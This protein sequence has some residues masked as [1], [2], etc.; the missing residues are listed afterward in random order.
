PTAGAA[1]ASTAPRRG[2]PA[3]GS[4]RLE[5][6]GC[7]DHVLLMDLRRGEVEA[8]PPLHRLH[9]VGVGPERVEGVVRTDGKI[10]VVTDESTA[11][12]VT[13]VDRMRAHLLAGAR[14]DI[15]DEVVEA[16]VVDV[17]IDGRAL[18]SALC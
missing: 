13:A 15:R 18:D 7:G 12:V 6:A 5:P 4:P 14:S 1:G 17:P 16:R 2:V 9:V 10:G 8:I 11:E 3:P